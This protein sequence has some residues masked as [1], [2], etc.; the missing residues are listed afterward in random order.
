MGKG[1][2]AQSWEEFSVVS[3]LPAVVALKLEE[4]PLLEIKSSEYTTVLEPCLAFFNDKADILDDLKEPETDE[5]R[6]VLGAFDLQ[7]RHLFQLQGDHRRKAR[8]DAGL[9]ATLS[10]FLLAQR[11]VPPA[12]RCEHVSRKG[13]HA[14]MKPRAYVL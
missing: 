3:C 8:S 14:L 6:C 13:V 1:E 5:N 9:L 10:P 2:W 7:E 11:Q 12:K 4:V